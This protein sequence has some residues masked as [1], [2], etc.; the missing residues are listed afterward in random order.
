VNEA[1]ITGIPSG[2]SPTTQTSNRV[3]VVAPA[4]VAPAVV[5]PA[6]PPRGEQFAIEKSQKIQ[7]SAGGFTTAPLT[8]AVGQIVDYQIIVK[9]TGPTTLTFTGFVDSKCDPGTIAG[10]PAAVA[11]GPGSS[12]T[13]TCSRI[14]TTN[15][16]VLNQASITG[17]AQ[18]E[19]PLSETSNQVEVKVAGHGLKPCEASAPPFHGPTGPK[20]SPFTVR[21]SSAGVQQITF[22]LDGRKLKTLK[23]SQAKGGKFAIRIDPRPLS[24]GRHRLSIKGTMIDPVCGQVAQASSFV[25]PFT[26][27]RPIFTG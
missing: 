17:T 16:T 11:V 10:A 6:A 22:Y 9:N 1:T 23:H 12:T 4:V 26:Q 15:E 2:G 3:E 13:Y 5:A 14:L 24:P 20:R 18:G 8:G 21:V 27:S 19:P 25:R 7:G